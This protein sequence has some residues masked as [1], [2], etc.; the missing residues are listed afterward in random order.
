MEKRVSMHPHKPHAT[1]QPSR[2]SH[3]HRPRT[4]YYH[5]I[6]P[7]LRISSSHKEANMVATLLTAAWLTGQQR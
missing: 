7:L 3:T 1:C 6:V 2:F 5:S 4:Q